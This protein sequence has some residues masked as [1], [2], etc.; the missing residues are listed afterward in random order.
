[1]WKKIKKEVEITMNIYFMIYCGLATMGLGMTLVEHGKPKEGNHN[2]FISLVSAVIY[3][4]LIYK[5]IKCGF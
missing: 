5:A 2:F 3:I 1:M 4:L